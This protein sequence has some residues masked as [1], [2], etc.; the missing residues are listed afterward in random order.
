MAASYQPAKGVIAQG[1]DVM[2]TKATVLSEFRQV[3]SENNKVIASLDDTFP[4][5]DCGLDSLC[6]AIVVARLEVKLGCDPFSS[7]EEMSFPVTV[8]EFV[9]L[10]EK[11]AA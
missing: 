8:G 3:A 9:A 6:F 11:H 4:L 2:T 5:L 1:P 10:Y 7:A